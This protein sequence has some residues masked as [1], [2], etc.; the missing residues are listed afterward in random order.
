VREVDIDVED[1]TLDMEALAA[2][3]TPRTKLVAVGYASNAV[4]T[5]N[6]VRQVVQLAREVGALSFID[7]VH[8]APHGP[9]DVGDLDCDFLAC[10]V[11]KFFGPHIGVLYGK[12]KQLERLRPDKVRPAS[13]AIPERWMTGTQ[14]HE[15]LAGTTAAVNYLAAIGGWQGGPDRRTALLDA[16]TAIKAYEQQPGDAF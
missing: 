6:D 4:G 9:I 11:Y 5:I 10:S 2:A 8:Y 1:C 16:M 12:R 3:I 14:S 7:A 13:D 15:G